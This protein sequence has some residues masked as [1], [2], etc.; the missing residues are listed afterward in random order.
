MSTT[1]SEFHVYVT[2]KHRYGRKVEK[3]IQLRKE[4]HKIILVHENDFWDAIEDL[5]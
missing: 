1:I 3:A 4:G 5:K 2:L